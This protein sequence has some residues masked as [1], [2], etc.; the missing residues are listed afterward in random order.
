MKDPA[1]PPFIFRFRMSEAEFSRFVHQLAI[2]FYRR[3]KPRT[4]ALN[5]LVWLVIWAVLALVFIVVF[6]HTQRLGDPDSL[7]LFMILVAFFAGGLTIQWFM[8]WSHRQVIRG[9]VQGLPS[10]LD[11]EAEIDETMLR[12]RTGPYRFSS[13]LSDTSQIAELDGGFLLRAGLNG[14]YLPAHAFAGEDQ[15]RDVLRHLLAQLA[16]EAAAI[17]VK[18]I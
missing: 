16:P 9:M 12:W 17:S 14:V 5:L 7:L 11:I 10:V 18:G 4:K 13:P 15:K 3:R 1:A 6:D 2:M 8:L